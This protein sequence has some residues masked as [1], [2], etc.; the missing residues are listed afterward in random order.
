M[1]RKI[2]F[3]LAVLSMVTASGCGHG[4]MEAPFGFLEHTTEAEVTTEPTT[5]E[6]KPVTFIDLDIDLPTTKPTESAATE[7]PT[8][9]VPDENIIIETAT[10]PA[11][12]ENND[13]KYVIYKETVTWKEAEAACEELGGHLAY[14]KTKAQYDAIISELDAKDI[15]YVWVGGLSFENG[16]KLTTKW[17]DDTPTSFIDDNGLWFPGEPSGKDNTSSSKV[18]EPFLMLWKIK[19]DWSFNDSSDMSLSLFK[20]QYFGFVCELD[21]SQS[22][23]PA[24]SSLASSISGSVKMGK[25]VTK[26]DDLSVR[27]GPSLNCERIGFVKKGDI[28][29]ITGSDGDWY[30]IKYGDRTGYVSSQYVS[31]ID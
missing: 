28:I 1:R 26:V 9:E 17:L 25:V 20:K 3:I 10:L 29:Q 19:D 31:I 13:K 27:E 6:E 8:S 5:E 7:P 16:G 22:G 14:I 21:D 24:L 12:P 15:K 18:N 4:I 11:S 2:C 23:P 30:T